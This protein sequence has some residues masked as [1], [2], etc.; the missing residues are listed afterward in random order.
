MKTKQTLRIWLQ[1]IRAP[2]LTTTLVPVLTGAACALFYRQPAAWHLLAP[3]MV[4]A[5]LLHAGTNLLNDY[6]DDQKGVDGPDTYGSSK[7]IQQKLLE[8]RQLLAGGL[9]LLAAGSLFALSLIPARGEAILALAVLGLVGA[10]GYTGWPIGYKYFAM[11]D[12]LVFL[13]MG[14]LMVAGAHYALTGLWDIRV[15]LVALPIGCLVS[16]ILHGNNLRDRK[17]DR[18]KGVRTLANTF[19]LSIAQ[20]E[21]AILVIG[22]YA[23]TMILVA[24]RALPWISILVFLSLPLALK[25]LRTV[26]G[27]TPSS[28]PSALAHIDRQTAVLHLAFGLLSLAALALGK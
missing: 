21:Y 18:N 16:A 19:P 28:P 8:P 23:I 5:L 2:F 24:T 17:H 4:A 12:I 20:G 1:A 26:L 7:V 3:I 6:F 11:G 9:V 14:P 25:N 22:A 13:L 27:I 15:F 10:Y